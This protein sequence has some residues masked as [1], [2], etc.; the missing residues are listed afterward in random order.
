MDEKLRMNI[1]IH[2]AI[3]KKKKKKMQW[4][5]TKKPID[6]SKWNSEVK[7]NNQKK[8]AGKEKQEKAKEKTKNKW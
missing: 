3:T 4:L 7:L 2:R 5:M 1:V 8:K 6:K